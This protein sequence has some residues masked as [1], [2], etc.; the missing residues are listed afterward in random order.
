MAHISEHHSEEEGEGN[1]RE[2]GGVDLL[3]AGNSV[4]VCDLLGDHGVGVSVEGGGRLGDFQ[5]LQLR[6]WHDLVDVENEF[7]LLLLRQVQVGH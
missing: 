5:L 6:G 2:D 3:I 4:G 1:C 7:L